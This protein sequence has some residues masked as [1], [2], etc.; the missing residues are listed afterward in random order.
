M[1]TVNT[2]VGKQQNTFRLVS[3]ETSVRWRLPVGDVNTSAN[4]F[5]SGNV[6][7]IAGSGDNRFLVKPSNQSNRPLG[8][9]FDTHIPTLDECAPNGD[10]GTLILNNHVGQISSQCAL[11]GVSDAAVGSKLSFGISG[12]NDGKFKIAE[13]GDTTVAYVMRQLGN[14]WT[15]Y[16]W[17]V[18]A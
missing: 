10:L 11:S 13:T 2:L 14:G 1:P 3:E 6:L 17:V 7:T 12:G 4:Q 9:A 16:Y 18:P 8:V 15:E 5:I